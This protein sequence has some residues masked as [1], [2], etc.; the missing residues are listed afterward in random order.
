[1]GIKISKSHKLVGFKGKKTSAKLR[2]RPD[3]VS[4]KA[5]DPFP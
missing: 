1:M 5:E 2:V 3:D 4:K